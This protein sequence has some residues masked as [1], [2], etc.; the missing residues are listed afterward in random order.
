MSI[1]FGEKL[2]GKYGEPPGREKRMF[3]NAIASENSDSDAKVNL[4]AAY[5]YTVDSLRAFNEVFSDNDKAAKFKQ[6]EILGAELE[7][8]GSK[9]FSENERDA[10]IL[11]LEKIESD[12]FK[13]FMGIKNLVEAW[14]KNQDTQ[15]ISFQEFI[16]KN[17]QIKELVNSLAAKLARIEGYGKYLDAIRNN[18]ELL[19]QALNTV[20]PNYD[21]ILKH[22]IVMNKTSPGGESYNRQQNK[23][24]EA[25]SVYFKGIPEATLKLADSLAE[26]RFVLRI[27][28]ER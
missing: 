6:L 13:V 17:D 10:I 9:P 26:L 11:L 22:K 1:P 3:L 14:T 12:F 23:I 2:F 7:K 15:P 27:G 24:K 8:K 19:D 18:F 21:E 16:Q 25:G 4:M 20:P 5:W 28:E